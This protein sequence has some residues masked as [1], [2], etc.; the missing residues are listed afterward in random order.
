MPTQSEPRLTNRGAALLVVDLQTKLVATI[1]TADG[2]I[3]TTVRLIR[4]AR[5][6]AIPVFATEQVPSKLGP[7]VPELAGL[8]PDPLPKATFHAGGAK[9]LCAALA[10]NPVR[11]VALVGIE[12]HICVAQPALELLPRGYQVQVPV[13]AVG[14]RFAV[15]HEVALRRLERAGVI[16]TTAEATLFEWVETAEHP[17]F[18]AIAA[19]VKERTGAALKAALRAE[20]GLS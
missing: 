1:P 4:G 2:V 15:D 9:G 20:I 11:H 13:D 12:T 14:S 8:L 3:S 16:L 10:A 7:T 5:A 18:R 6:L 17:Q 19:L